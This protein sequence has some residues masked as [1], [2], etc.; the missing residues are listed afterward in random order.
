MKSEGNRGPRQRDHECRAPGQGTD[1]PAGGGRGEVGQGQ[2]Q[3]EEVG[4]QGAFQP[5]IM[6][7]NLGDVQNPQS[8]FV[9]NSLVTQGLGLGTSTYTALVQ[10]LVGERNSHKPAQR[11]LK[12]ITLLSMV[13][14]TDDEV[15]CCLGCRRGAWWCVGGHTS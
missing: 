15:M 3:G 9:G 4:P 14:L 12:K 8:Y 5:G 2:G 13:L 7:S 1:W 10:S 11:R 6:S